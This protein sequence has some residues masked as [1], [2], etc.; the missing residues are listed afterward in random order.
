MSSPQTAPMIIRVMEVFN[1]VNPATVCSR[2]AGPKRAVL[3]LLAPKVAARRLLSA[4][5]L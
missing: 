3:A 5:V 4:A 2:G 1:T